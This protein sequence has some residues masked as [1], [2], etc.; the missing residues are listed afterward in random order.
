MFDLKP[1]EVAIS[2]KRVWSRPSKA[3]ERSCSLRTGEDPLELANWVC[4][5]TLARAVAVRGEGRGQAGVC[6][7]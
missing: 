1:G 7:R 3:E 5:V 2:R 4:L 6:G